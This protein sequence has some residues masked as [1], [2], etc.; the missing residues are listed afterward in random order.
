M[1]EAGP[2]TPALTYE[3]PPPPTARDGRRSAVAG[4][5]SGAAAWA[6]WAGIYAT[7]YLLRIVPLSYPAFVVLRRVAG[8]LVLAGGL[9]AVVF[10][11][12]ALV[13]A[14]RDK[15]RRAARLGVLALA[16]GLGAYAMVIATAWLPRR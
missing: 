12:V 10:G 4:I 5:A 6:G 11:I 15:T 7:G 13:R 9:L 14:R 3:T 16:L 2:Q 8:V 1:L